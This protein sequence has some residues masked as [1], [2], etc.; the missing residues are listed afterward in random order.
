VG[1]KFQFFNSSGQDEH[2]ANNND[3]QCDLCLPVIT[4]K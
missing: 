3:F 2:P 1:N 4:E